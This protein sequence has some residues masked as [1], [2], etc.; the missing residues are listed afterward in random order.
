MRLLLRT[1]SILGVLTLSVATVAAQC[2]YPLPT[3]EEAIE[4]TANVQ[5]RF[6]NFSTERRCASGAAFTDVAGLDGSSLI[7][8]AREYCI[9]S[10]RDNGAFD[11]ASTLNRAELAK[12][13]VTAFDIP[14]KAAVAGSFSDVQPGDW[15]AGYVQSVKDAGIVAGYPDGT[16]KPGQAVNRAEATK[17]LLEAAFYSTD[18]MK[19]AVP[20]MYNALYD[21]GAKRGVLPLR[22]RDVNYD[23]WFVPYVLMGEELEVMS[24]LMDNMRFSPGAGITRAEA[25]ALLMRIRGANMVEKAEVIDQFR[26]NCE[27]IVKKYTHSIAD[28]HPELN[29]VSTENFTVPSPSRDRF[30]GNEDAPLTLVSY[31]DFLCPYCKRFQSTWKEI[32]FEYGDQLNVVHRHFPLGSHGDAA[33]YKA[34]AVEC[35][36][37]LGSDDDYWSATDS[38]YRD[39]SYNQSMEDIMEDVPSSIDR[40]ALEECMNDEATAKLIT[41]SYAEGLAFGVNG[42]PANYIYDHRYDE[43]FFVGGAAE[44]SRF[45]S[46]IDTLLQ[47]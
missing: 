39:Q 21:Q 45:K 6:Y 29:E 25:L 44:A 13:I 7:Q 31:E 28:E 27:N 47:Y 34:R 38:M 22:V 2:A 8:D 43:V 1:L 40:A 46:V 16:F 19:K 18:V 4:N 14:A 12:I 42:T 9:I 17:M 33:V 23:Q 32:A 30:F 11:P 26:R 37:M 5:A 24:G 15:Y 10:G 20:N 3:Q 36:G 35:A 41:D